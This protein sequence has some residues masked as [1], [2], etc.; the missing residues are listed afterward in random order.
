MAGI[1][2]A[3]REDEKIWVSVAAAHYLPPNQR[4]DEFYVD[5]HDYGNT[6]FDGYAVCCVRLPK[7][8]RPGMEVDIR[9]A[10]SDWTESPFDDKVN[11]D[12]NKVK[13]VGV[14]RPKVPVER[15]EEPT[16]CL[17]ISLMGEESR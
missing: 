2:F 15:Y 8:W 13:L 17:C 4:V 3:T 1:Y 11:F 9:W 5:R 7:N 10:V 14:Y 16:M 12:L 6:G